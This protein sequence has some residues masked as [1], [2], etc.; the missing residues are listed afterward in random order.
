MWDRARIAKTIDSERLPVT[1]RQVKDHLRE[2]GDAG[3]VL[4]AML[5]AR[6]LGLPVTWSTLAIAELTGADPVEMLERW[7]FTEQEL[8]VAYP[9]DEGCGKNVAEGAESTRLR[10]ECRIVYDA[11]PGSTPDAA[12]M[13][14]ALT[15]R[16]G[17]C[18]PDGANA[19]APSVVSTLEKSVA[20]LARELQPSA[21]SV[22]VRLSPSAAAEGP[23]TFGPGILMIE[24]NHDN[25]EIADALLSARGFSR[26]FWATNGISGLA[27]LNRLECEIRAVLLDVM[28]PGMDGFEVCRAIKQD[29]RLA[30]TKVIMVTAKA[31]F[32]DKWVGQQAGA[33]EY[34]TKPVDFNDLLEKLRRQLAT[35]EGERR[36]AP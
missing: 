19:A 20:N 31:G 12:S 30:S 34:V 23:H 16:I 11:A 22:Q 3:R 1:Q 18:I 21:R 32:E 24:D 33:D 35:S 4:E 27:I 28:M 8:I 26:T 13:H 5:F 14:A 2:G 9:L 7:V 10:A 29:P 17:A 25:L 6:E 36:G 15:R